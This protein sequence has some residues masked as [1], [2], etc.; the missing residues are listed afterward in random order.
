MDSQHLKPDYYD[1]TNMK[2]VQI[3]AQGSVII[4]RPKI[5]NDNDLKLEQRLITL[6]YSK[7]LIETILYPKEYEFDLGIIEIYPLGDGVQTVGYSENFPEIFIKIAEKI[8]TVYGNRT[9]NNLIPQRVTNDIDFPDKQLQEDKVSGQ[10]VSTSDKTDNW[11]P[12]EHIPEHGSDRVIIEYWCKRWK[13]REIA[14]QLDYEPPTIRNMI[15]KL[16][17]EY[18]E[19][20]IP[21]DEERK[22]KID[23][24]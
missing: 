15:S 21:R 1:P 10:Q 18:P 8:Q 9:H 20:K 4:N 23:D 24:S 13:Y 14:H 19:A 3:F 2:I 12:W 6:G 7:V 22:R 17:K 16:R 11:K 5:Q